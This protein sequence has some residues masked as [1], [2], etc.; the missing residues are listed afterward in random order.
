MRESTDLRPA[1]QQ[2]LTQWS[3]QHWQASPCML[4]GFDCQLKAS[5]KQ[6]AMQRGEREQGPFWGQH[7]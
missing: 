2:A 6:Q 1:E 7:T 3:M 5:Q 4:N